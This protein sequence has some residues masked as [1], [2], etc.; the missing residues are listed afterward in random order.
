MCVF[1]QKK[2]FFCEVP[3]ENGLVFVIFATFYGKN[4][5]YWDSKSVPFPF[6]DGKILSCF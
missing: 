5:V 1:S 2:P 3:H 4:R 6:L